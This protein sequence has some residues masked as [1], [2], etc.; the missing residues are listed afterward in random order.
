MWSFA[1][2]QH[3]MFYMLCYLGILL[4]FLLQVG[5]SDRHVADKCR[6][7]AGG[8]NHSN[9][10]QWC[11]QRFNLLLSV[12]ECDVVLLGYCAALPPME[13]FMDVSRNARRQHFFE[14]S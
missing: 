1:F 12:S 2:W 4:S 5:T 7:M 13:H 14:V 9:A 8:N 10:L 11:R 6:S 3:P